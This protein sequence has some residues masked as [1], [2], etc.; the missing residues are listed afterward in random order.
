MILQKNP[1][2]FLPISSINGANLRVIAT[3]NILINK[4]AAAVATTVHL[5]RL[6]SFLSVN[7]NL[8]RVVLGRG[9]RLRATAAAKGT[10][11]ANPR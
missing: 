6:A 10:A 4:R 2:F 11:V 3:N 9:N 8:G 1:F 7:P 5:A